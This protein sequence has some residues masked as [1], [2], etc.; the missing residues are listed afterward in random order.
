MIK[1]S[2]SNGHISEVVCDTPAEAAQV[3]S[4]MNK[5]QSRPVA[6]KRVSGAISKIEETKPAGETRRKHVAK[7][8]QWM[9]SEVRHLVQNSNVSPEK[10]ANDPTLRAR[11]SAGAIRNA[12]YAVRSNT[13]FSKR[14]NA[15]V[16][17]A[18]RTASA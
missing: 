17:E 8:G 10:L 14:F 18:R 11:H 4:S 2:F 7:Y 12:A 9:L 3:V 5:Q 1:I 15:L 16:S 6:T 13:P